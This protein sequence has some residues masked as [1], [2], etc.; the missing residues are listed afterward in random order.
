M[1]CSVI[2][3]VIC[4]GLVSV[5]AVVVSGYISI[6]INRHSIVEICD[7]FE[8]VPANSTFLGHSKLT[9]CSAESGQYDVLNIVNHF[10][11][12]IDDLE[13]VSFARWR[14]VGVVILVTNK[15]L[16]LNKISRAVNSLRGGAPRPH[17]TVAFLVRGINRLAA[18]R[19]IVVDD[20]G[21]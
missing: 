1:A 17:V 18:R 7:Q 3:S 9:A 4:L 15:N 14:D 13:P 10:A 19:P 6:V 8:L 2:R 20:E 5:V 12:W 21:L 11:H 16:V